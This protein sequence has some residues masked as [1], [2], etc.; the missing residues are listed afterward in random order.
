V[1]ERRG[2]PFDGRI[3]LVLNEPNDI[4]LEKEQHEYAGDLDRKNDDGDCG[5]EQP[6]AQ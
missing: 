1:G 5:A 3:E 2:K 4:S 6:K